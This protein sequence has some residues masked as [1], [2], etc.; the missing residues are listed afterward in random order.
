MKQIIHKPTFIIAAMTCFCFLLTSTGWLAWE[1][2]LMEQVS[3]RMSDI[4]TMV[5]SYLLQAGGVGL[6]AVLLRTKGL[7]AVKLVPSAMILHTLCLIPAV[8]SRN[9]S[10]TL[11]SGFLV[12]LFC[13]YIAGYYLYV[14]TRKIEAR[15]RATTL[16]IGYGVSIL[17]SWLLSA[18]DGLYYSNKVWVICLILTAITLLLFKR[19]ETLPAT[20]FTKAQ[21]KEEPGKLRALLW[22]V[23]AMV[24]LFSIVNNLGFA[25][26]AADIVHGIKTELSRLFYAWGL[27]LAGVLADRERKYGAAAALVSLI[28][29]FI[30]LALRNEPLSLTVFWAL[31]YFT[32]GFLSIFR[33]VVFSDLAEKRGLWFLSGFGLLIGRIGD[34]AGESTFLA[35]TSSQIALV[36][37]ST[38]LFLTAGF[39]FF[40]VF[41]SL[42]V[43]E[44]KQRQSEKEYFYAFAAQHDLSAREQDMLRLLLNKK[45]NT[46]IAEALSISENTV[47]FHI[48]NLLQKT[49]FKNRNELITAYLSRFGI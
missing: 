47:K 27:I 3:P 23:G 43:P 22:S 14:L 45:S 1:Y 29:P 46:E 24:L 49:G 41:N 4:M 39:L 18:F 33:M 30:M 26:S 6:F 28:I 19:T 16:G 21:Q 35:L 44:A 17:L 13:G 10:G 48:R 25:F 34:A 42:Y 11:V 2:H 31:S 38:L 8:L 36:F 7:F 5:F 20:E 32:Y 40:R 9:L 15:R 12:S 37:L